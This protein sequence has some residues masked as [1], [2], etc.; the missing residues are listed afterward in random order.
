MDLDRKPLPVGLTIPGRSCVGCWDKTA[1]TSLAQ[2][3]TLPATMAATQTRSNRSKFVMGV[4]SCFIKLDLRPAAPE[5]ADSW[6]Y[7]SQKL[8]AGESRG[9][10]EEATDVVLLNGP[11]VS[12][13][14]HSNSNVYA[15][16]LELLPALVRE[17]FI[18]FLVVSSDD[19]TPGHKWDIDNSPSRAQRTLQIKGRKT[20]KAQEAGTQQNADFQA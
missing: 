2:P 8:R 6:A 3:W 10:R 16:T 18:F 5:G 12:V 1:I 17:G 9:P 14:L 7:K 19:W 4:T 11:D 15:R 20:V 13:K